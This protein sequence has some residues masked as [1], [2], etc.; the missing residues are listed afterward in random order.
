[1]ALSLRQLFAIFLALTCL[2]LLTPFLLTEL[3]PRQS[4]LQP[5]HASSSRSTRRSRNDTVRTLLEHGPAHA[6]IDL[7]FL[8][9]AYEASQAEAFFAD[10]ERILAE[11]FAQPEAPFVGL[12]PLVS[13][14]WKRS[15]D[16][17][18]Y[19]YEGGPD[20]AKCLSP[21][22]RLDRVGLRAVLW[23][24]PILHSGERE[25]GRGRGHGAHV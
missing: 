16:N 22:E 2:A 11:H 7:V 1:M 4:I 3:S 17:V 23:Q 10:A 14:H 19:A 5:P 8:S 21:E 13:T 25:K 9:E 24:P 15:H 12:L 6:A 18:W 20:A